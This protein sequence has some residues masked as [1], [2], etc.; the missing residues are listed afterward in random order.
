MM[1]EGRGLLAEA[2][3]EVGRMRLAE[4]VDRAA[5]GLEDFLATGRGAAGEAESLLVA[6]R[7]EL[8]EMQLAET[9]AI[10]RR[11]AEEM[12]QRTRHL[13]IEMR[14]TT[15]DLR[16]VMETLDRLLERLH[17]SPSDIIFSRPPAASVPRTPGDGE[18]R[19]P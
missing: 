4:R 16:R 3:G 12:D 8:A 7:E 6:M 19:R 5:E 9:T 2:R 15:A 14:D 11:L 10:T 1:T 18:E 13:S 17:S